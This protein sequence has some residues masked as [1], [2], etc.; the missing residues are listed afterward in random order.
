VFD[1]NFKSNVER[2]VH[3]VGKGLH[4]IGVTPDLLTA[5]GLLMSVATAVVIGSGRPRL[6]FFLLVAS[7][8]PDLLDGAVAKASGRASMR[9]AFFD[10]V[11]DRA[12]DAFLLGGIGWYLGS[13]HGFEASML[14]FAVLG[15]STL[16]SYQRAKAEIYNLDAKGGLMER[17]ERIIALGVGLVFPGLLVPILGIMLALTAMTAVQRFVKVWKQADAPVPV[18]RRPISETMAERAASRRVAR[19]ARANRL[20]TAEVTTVAERMEGWRRDRREAAANRE[21]R[22]RER[23]AR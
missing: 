21:A 18:V 10:S 9:G 20:Q 13:K 16:I 6:G 11:A 5:T 3:P 19:A 15:T 2:A 12:T 17:A 23:A 8:L 7:A 22:R 1:G 14:A 4:R